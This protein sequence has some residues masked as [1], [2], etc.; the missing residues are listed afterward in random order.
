MASIK[1]TSQWE[2]EVHMV[3]IGDPVA[4][5]DSGSVNMSVQDLANRTLY[6]KNILDAATQ[7]LETI[8]SQV[9]VLK[10]SDVLLKASNLSD[11]ASKSTARNNISAAAADHA[12]DTAYLKIA[13][14]LSDIDDSDA[15]RLALGAAALDHLHDGIYA[16]RADLIG[17]VIMW[18]LP[19]PPKYFLEFNGDL[20]LIKDFPELYARV[21]TR[22]GGDGKT[23]FRLFDARGGLPRAWDNGRGVDPGRA[24][25]TW[26]E[27]AI[28]N[29][30]GEAG[31]MNT[32]GFGKTGSGDDDSSKNHSGPFT[33][34]SWK[35]RRVSGES[36]SGYNLKFDASRVV[37]TADE[38]RPYNFSIMFCIR[39]A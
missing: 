10:H 39:Y 33:W 25:V 36:G 16:R 13:R 24:I 12:H 38:N 6:L 14:N 1:E 3:S 19:T 34:G 17:E 26:Q 29:I 37:P 30:V 22:W 2:N 28:R 9:G 23:T 15:A 31:Y 27:D 11:V 20:H 32:G 21:G 18:P 5:G 35:A 4:G 8:K 7:E